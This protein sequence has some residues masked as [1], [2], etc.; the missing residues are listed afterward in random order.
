MLRELDAAEKRRVALRG[1]RAPDLPVDIAIEVAYD[2]LDREMRPFFEALAIFPAP[3]ELDAAAAIWD[4]DADVASTTLSRLVNLALIDPLP[5]ADHFE[6]HHRIRQFA[7][8]LFL[9]QPERSVQLV[10]RY[11]AHTLREAAQA[12]ARWASGEAKPHATDRDRYL[13]WEHLPTAW[14]RLNGEDPGWPRPTTMD[15]WIADF[16][17]HGQALLEATLPR[18]A[19]RAWLSQSLAAAERLN[20]AATITWLRETYG[21]VNAPPSA[22]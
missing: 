11:V 1:S 22:Y 7:Q 16:P 14:R 9:S 8:E 4:V 13:L 12:S 5:G 18:P 10:A 3:F 15:Q 20:D 21:E 2:H 17:R 6:M 19:Y